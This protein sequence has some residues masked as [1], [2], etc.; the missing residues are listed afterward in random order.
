M[1]DAQVSDACGF[2]VWVQIPSLAPKK[3]VV[4]YLSKKD[5]MLTFCLFKKYI[6]V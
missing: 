1:A 6:V 4:L 5:F 3:I 2:T